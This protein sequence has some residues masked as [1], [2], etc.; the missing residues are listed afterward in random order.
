MKFEQ[1]KQAAK[2]VGF[3]TS[4]AEDENY[5]EAVVLK[6]KLEELMLKL[7]SL[8]GPAQN[9]PSAQAQEAVSKFGGITKGQTLYFWQEGESFVF[10][11]LWPWQ[12]GEH[13]T[14]KMSKG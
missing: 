8:F 9:K 7:D 14:L 3:E 11:M 2:D 12:D 6:N 10:A 13:I 4:R 1:L 5:L